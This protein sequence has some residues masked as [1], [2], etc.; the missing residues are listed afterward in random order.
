M[1]SARACELCFYHFLSNHY[2]QRKVIGKGSKCYCSAAVVCWFIVIYSI[3]LHQWLKS[4]RRFSV[5]CLPAGLVA[6][7][8]VLENHS[9]ENECLEMLREE[10]TSKHERKENLLL[11]SYLGF[12]RRF[13]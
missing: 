9:D 3:Y 11:L 6:Q 13:G 10:R 2:T 5:C 1:C 4:L 8:D 12:I 7:Q